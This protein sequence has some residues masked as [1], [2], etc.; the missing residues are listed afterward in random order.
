MKSRCAASALADARTRPTWGVDAGIRK[1]IWSDKIADSTLHRLSP[2]VLWRTKRNREAADEEAFAAFR[3]VIE[4]IERAKDAL[5]LAVPRGR[6]P[7]VPLAEALWEFESAIAEAAEGMPAWR[8]S[9]MEEVW[10]ACRSA[11]DRSA[12]SAEEL[13]LGVPPEGYEE[14]YGRLDELLEPLEAFGAAA[15]RFR[16]RRQ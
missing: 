15:R 7:V 5:L 13:R 8:T 12:R 6:A 3:R 10:A 4:T 1:T 9:D 11:L 14:L 2:M 16:G